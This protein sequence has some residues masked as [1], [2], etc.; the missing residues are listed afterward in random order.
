MSDRMGVMTMPA[1][2]SCNAAINVAI[3]DR[4]FISQM[5]K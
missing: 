2:A 4:T 3:D 5:L 1:L